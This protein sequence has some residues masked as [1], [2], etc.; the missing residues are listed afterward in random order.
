MK[1]LQEFIDEELRVDYQHGVGAWVRSGR[2]GVGRTVTRTVNLRTVQK[3]EPEKKEGEYT[4]Q[5]HIK[6]KLAAMSKR[7]ATRDIQPII[8][9]NTLVDGHHQALVDARRNRKTKSIILPKIMG[10]NREGYG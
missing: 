6:K 7:G 9:N 2:H 4:A 3:T 5:P 8:H 10:K 1:T